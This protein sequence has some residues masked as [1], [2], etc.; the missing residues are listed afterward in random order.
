MR[1]LIPCVLLMMILSAC[2]GGSE[3]EL[4]DAIGDAIWQEAQPEDGSPPEVLTEGNAGCIGEAFV[5]AVGF[6]TFEAQGITADAVTGRSGSLADLVEDKDLGVGDPEVSTALY[7]G[8]QECID[9]QGVL[10]PAMSSE[11]EIA[12]ESA[13]CFIGGLLDEEAFRP[14][15]VESLIGGSLDVLRNPDPATM[16]TLLGLLNSCLTQEEMAKVISG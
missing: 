7:D 8:V 6:E 9:L 10:A 1:R 12:S 2:G 3:A 15:L 5:S 13:D 4:A 11:L 14:A 16:G